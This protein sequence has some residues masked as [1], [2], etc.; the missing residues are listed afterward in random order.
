[1]AVSG[2]RPWH[3]TLLALVTPVLAAAASQAAPAEPRQVP[4][5]AAA[6]AT[7]GEPTAPSV[8]MPNRALRHMVVVREGKPRFVAHVIGIDLSAADI[9]FVTTAADNT[10]GMEFVALRTSTVLDRLNALVAVNASYFLPFAG[11]SPGGEDYYPHE[12][13]PANASG[14]V[15]ASGAVASPVE[16]DLDLRVNAIVCFEGLAV[17]I[18]DGQVCPAGFSSGIAAGPR[19]LASGARRSFETF[20]N[21]YAATP[22]P[23]TAI[24][25]SAD[26]KRAWIVVVDGRQK[27]YS[28]GATLE[29]L[30]TLFLELGAS[31]A[32]NL[33]GGGSSTM[34]VA[35]EDG[36]PQVI[37][38]P[39]HTGVPGRERPVAN[40]LAVVP[41]TRMP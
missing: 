11:G 16:T 6:P 14:A 18:A 22:Q 38:R 26:R 7:V 12:G 1:M 36:T 21:N 29:A 20:D 32:I 5:P 4:A 23:R 39:I 27:G 2:F 40:H 25:I 31:D 24:G 33:D 19:M 35:G 34:V 37:N 8:A 9:A 10:R 13:D 17:A 30:S 28:D 41:I 3:G 15:V